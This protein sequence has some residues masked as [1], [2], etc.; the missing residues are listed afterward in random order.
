ML[1]DESKHMIG[2]TCSNDKCKHVQY[3][4][5]RVVCPPDGNTIRIVRGG[6]DI[7]TIKCEKCGCDIE[8]DVDCEGYK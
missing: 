5:K 8:V 1:K 6:S 2:V 4:D 3:I 7:I